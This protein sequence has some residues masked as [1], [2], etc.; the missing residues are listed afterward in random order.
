MGSEILRQKAT[1]VLTEDV[2]TEP[3][4]KIID[5]MIETASQTPERGF[6]TAGLA[7]P[8]I[9]EPLRIVL[10][11]SKGSNQKN[12]SYDVLINPELQFPSSELID[13]E[14]SCLSTPGLCG[15]VKRYREVQVSYMDRKA[16]RKREKITGERAIF[17]QH[18]YDHL[19]GVLWVDKVTDT[20]TLYMCGS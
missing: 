9:A 12:P 3:V 5:D 19:D 1:A 16:E 10:I 2:A 14:E 17:V 11:M 13:S 18:E 4:Q 6:M 8:Q 20:K 15:V 7:A